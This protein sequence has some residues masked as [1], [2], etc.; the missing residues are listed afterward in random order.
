MICFHKAVKLYA[1]ELSLYKHNLYSLCEIK[2][3][4][5]SIQSDVCYS[6]KSNLRITT[7]PEIHSN[8]SSE[9]QAH[10]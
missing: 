10:I 6:I 3:K 2:H 8:S 7:K 4:F 9:I 5:R 1:N